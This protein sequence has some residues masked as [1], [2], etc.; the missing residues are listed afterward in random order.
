MYI[1]SAAPRKFV[2]GKGVVRVV[3]RLLFRLVVRRAMVRVLSVSIEFLVRRVDISPL[4]S[5]I[6]V[7]KTE[8]QVEKAEIDLQSL[9]NPLLP[10]HT[11]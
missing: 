8:F 1:L 5:L 11:F 10:Q 2:R 4:Q 9:A 7:Q 6:G 3:G